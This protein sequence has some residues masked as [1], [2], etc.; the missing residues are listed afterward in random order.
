MRQHDRA[1]IL[2]LALPAMLWTSTPALSSSGSQASSPTQSSAAVPAPAAADHRG[3]QEFRDAVVRYLA[4]RQRVAQELPGL[5]ASMSA[6]E[7]ARTTDALA[8]AVQRLR[9]NA[10][11]GEFFTPDCAAAL[12]RRIEQTVQDA[13]LG[14]V[15]A[16]IDDEP[17]RITQPR[18]H[19]VMPADAQM[20]T[21]PP[22]LLQALP[23][24]P[25]T[26]E[27]RIV[28]NYL[29]LRD[30]EAAM[31]LDFIAIVPRASAR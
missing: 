25:A 8:R 6:A 19:M 26:L 1:W 29:V 7:L 3:L 5:T 9:P 28:G 14:P 21:M 2:G 27:Y 4:A 10:R 23:A 24:L 22:S 30:A 17:P 12:Q 11:Q 13:N 20:A 15:L 16:G 31:I 18:I